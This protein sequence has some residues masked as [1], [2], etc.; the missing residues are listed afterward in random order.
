MNDEKRKMIKI[1]L[2]E[3]EG[4]WAEDLG[5]GRA[6]I[7]NIPG[8]GP[9]NIDDIVSLCPTRDG[10]VQPDQ[11]LSRA[12]QCRTGIA[13]PEPYRVT[14]AALCEAYKKHGARVEG[15]VEGWLVIAH[16]I[17]FDPEAMAKAAGVT[18][19]IEGGLRPRSE[20]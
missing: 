13:Y 4:G 8:G 5:D 19:K 15:L 18:V 14:F 7:A 11:L 17:N 2:D 12:F 1:M 16:H 9:W 10:R 3:H 6:R 20:S